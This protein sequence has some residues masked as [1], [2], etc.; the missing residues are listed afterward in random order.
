[1]TLTACTLL[2]V[3]LVARPI[4]AQ[5]RPEPPAAASQPAQPSREESGF[6]K[7]AQ[8]AGMDALLRRQEARPIMP[9]RSAAPAGRD[10]GSEGGLWPDGALLIDRSGRAIRTGDRFEFE[11][12]VEGETTPRR[13]LLLPNQLLEL[14]EDE[15]DRGAAEFVISAQVTRHRGVNYLLLQ[16]VLRRV[17]NGNLGP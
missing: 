1:M 9:T 13:L 6:R 12:S 14:L 7:P 4:D 16:K 15:H 17:N 8:A 11:F 3:G 5:E 2:W 10:E